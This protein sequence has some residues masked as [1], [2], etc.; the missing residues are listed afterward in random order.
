LV[1]TLL[2]I[3][4]CRLLIL[5]SPSFSYLLSFSLSLDFLPDSAFFFFVVILKFCFQAARSAA[6][7]WRTK[8]VLSS[9]RFL[10]SVPFV[11]LPQSSVYLICVFF[12]FRFSAI[13]CH[14]SLFLLTFLCPVPFLFWFLRWV[15]PRPCLFDFQ[16]AVRTPTLL[17]LSSLFPH[18]FGLCRV[19]GL[20]G[21]PYSFGVAHVFPTF[22]I[23]PFTFFVRQV[24]T[25]LLF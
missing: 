20:R 18:V 16:L 25:N 2:H 5:C 11:R 22:G 12:F 4:T 24:L 6:S 17:N 14:L 3:R 13:V 21:L 1:F 7:L 8:L 10:H 19:S 9:S 23:P 15:A